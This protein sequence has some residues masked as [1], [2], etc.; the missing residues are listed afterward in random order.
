[1][2][3][4]KDIKPIEGD[5]IRVKRK[6]GYFHY[7]I[8]IENKDVIHFSGYQKDDILNSDNVDVHISSLNDF[9][10]SDEL[11][12]NY[13]F[14]SLFSRKEVVKRAKDLMK[15]YKKDKTKYN[16]INNNCEHVAREIYYGD[17]SSKQ[18]NNVAAVVAGITALGAAAI[19]AISI[20][21][22]KKK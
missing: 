7:G 10:K 17:H 8:V 15:R 9:I 13:P 20:N 12:V 6:A 18:V 5:L 2:A 1:M 19:T 11:E 14:D 3:F 22:N 4:K 16:L 21:K